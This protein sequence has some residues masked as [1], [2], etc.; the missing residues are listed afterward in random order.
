VP[1]KKGNRKAIYTID[2]VARVF[3]LIFALLLLLSVISGL[4]SPQVCWPLA[5]AGLCYSTFLLVNLF[6]V[7]YWIA[8]ANRFVLVSLISIL[9]GYKPLT[10]TVGFHLPQPASE[11]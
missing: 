5:L 4:V 3:N 11:Y 10:N 2:K 7:V 9:V 8:R 1:F 6:F